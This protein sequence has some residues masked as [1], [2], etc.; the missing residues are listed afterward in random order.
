M[1]H[2]YPVQM[3]MSYPVRMSVKLQV[4]RCARALIANLAYH[5][6][7][8]TARLASGRSVSAIHPDATCWC[9]FGAL[10]RAEHDIGIAPLRYAA[11]I[12]NDIRTH[13]SRSI[14]FINDGPPPTAGH[15]AA[16][17]AFDRQI[18]RYEA[19]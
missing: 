6:T 13:E 18:R 19:A 16:L 8:A 4:L 2:S 7:G 1:T 11:A 5:T 3:S 17:A 12:A 15:A 10:L 14:S 9:A